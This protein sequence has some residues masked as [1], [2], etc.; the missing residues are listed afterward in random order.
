V[1][2]VANSS[3]A[4]PEGAR[5]VEESPA[6]TVGGTLFEELGFS[7]VGPID[8]HDM[9]S[10]SPSCARQGARRGPDP[11]PRDHQ[12]GQGLRR[13]SRPGPRHRQVRRVTGEQKKPLQRAELHQGLRQTPSSRRPRTDDKIVA[14]T[15]AMPDGTGL[16]LF[17]KRFPTRTFDVGIAEQHGVTMCAG[18]APRAQALRAIYS[19]F[20]QRG[21]DQVVHDVAI[22]RLPVRFAID[23]AG[24]V[25]ADGATHA[26]SF[27]VAYLSNLPNFV[28]MAA[29]D[30]A[31]LCPHGPHRR[32]RSTTAQRLPLPARRRRGRRDA[33]PRPPLEIGKGRIVREGN[34]VAS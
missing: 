11:D 10:C 7:Y 27:D 13:N 23:R 18:M 34:R 2:A 19:T 5:P 9:D 3:Q 31:E 20:L 1:R 21:Y 17:G 8:G 6:A 26:G 12:E 32:S 16:D 14:V 28:V 30:E 25:G 29:S 22:Q 15:A 4:L 33:G 24:L